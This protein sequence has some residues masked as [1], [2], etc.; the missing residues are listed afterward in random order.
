MTDE[1][2]TGKPDRPLYPY[3]LSLFATVLYFALVVCAFGFITLIAGTEVV[4]RTDA[5]LLVG[6]TATAA[7]VVAVAVCLVRKATRLHAEAQSDERRTV[8]VP[9]GG[10]LVVGIV[11]WLVYALV[12]ALS[13]A[14][15]TDAPISFVFYA[16]ESLVRAYGISVGLLAAVVYVAFVLILSGMGE[17]PSRPL[18]PWERRE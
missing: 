10:A 17:H 3:V 5:G 15:Q 14:V 7:G 12:G 11:A 2:S 18:W 8:R 4:A 1:R 6:P 9:L 13:Y 16:A